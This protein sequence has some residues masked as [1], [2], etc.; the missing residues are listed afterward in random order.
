MPIRML[1]VDPGSCVQQTFRLQPH[2]MHRSN[3]TRPRDEVPSAVELGVTCA[4]WSVDACGNVMLVRSSTA[5]AR[6]CDNTARG[7]QAAESIGLK[8]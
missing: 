3:V 5:S 7:A 4:D 2:T 1:D 6:S 8:H